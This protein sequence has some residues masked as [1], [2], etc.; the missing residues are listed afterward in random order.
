MHWSRKTSKSVKPINPRVP[1]VLEGNEQGPNWE[2]FFIFPLGTLTLSNSVQNFHDQWLLVLPHY[3]LF[4][5]RISHNY[6]SLFFHCYVQN[7]EHIGMTLKKKKSL[8]LKTNHTWTW[9]GD[10]H[11]YLEFE[12]DWTELLDHFHWKRILILHMFWVQKEDKWILLPSS[13]SHHFMVNM[14]GK[15][16]RQWQIIFSRITKKRDCSH[17]VK[18]QSLKEKLLKI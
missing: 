13:G 17:E 4:Q 14:W 1:R 3:F 18:R 7:V 6:P 8:Q 15:K 5:M 9:Y 10:C 16:R 12:H 2:L 11:T